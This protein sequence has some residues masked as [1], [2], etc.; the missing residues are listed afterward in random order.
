M[1]GHLNQRPLGK[2][3]F[4][5]AGL[6][7]TRQ[8]AYSPP[9]TGRIETTYELQL[10]RDYAMSLAMCRGRTRCYDDVDVIDDVIIFSFFC[11]LCLCLWGPVHSTRGMCAQACGMMWM[12]LRGVDPRLLVGPTALPLDHS[13]SGVKAEVYD[14]GNG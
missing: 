4:E 13:S 5:A 3:A 9:L 1:W 10:L 2:V 14:R 8:V 11:I 7:G 12:L 6:L